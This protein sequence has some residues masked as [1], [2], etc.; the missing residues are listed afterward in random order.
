[1][2]ESSGALDIALIS[3]GKYYEQRARARSKITSLAIFPCLMLLAGVFVPRLQRFILS[4]LQGGEYSLGYFLRDTLGIL[5]C[6]VAVCWV[7]FYLMRW[8]LKSP[9]Y[10]VSADRALSR[11]PVYG[12]FRVTYALQ[13]WVQSIRLMLKA[14]FGVIESIKASGLTAGSPIILQACQKVEPMLNSQLEVSQALESTGAFPTMLIQYW[15]TGEQSGRMDDMLD[16]LEKYYAEEWQKKL[17]L[18]AMWIPKLMYGLFAIFIVIQIIQM[19]QGYVAQLNSP[20][21]MPH[22]GALNYK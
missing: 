12:T 13:Q 11:I 6:L 19:M 22:R 18:L 9:K 14:G 16:K 17:D 2:A 8:L 3:L 21:W 1:M 20:L 15:A 4:S 7:F 5:L 10:C